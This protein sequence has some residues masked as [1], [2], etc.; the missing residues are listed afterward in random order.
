MSKEHPSHRVVV[1]IILVREAFSIVP[2]SKPFKREFCVF[3]LFF[4]KEN[5]MEKADNVLW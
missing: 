4:F 5:I 3:V 1:R 2:H